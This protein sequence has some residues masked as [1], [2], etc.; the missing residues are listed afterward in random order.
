[1]IF[2]SNKNPIN[3][4]ILLSTFILLL[5]LYFLTLQFH[6]FISLRFRFFSKNEISFI[7][8]KLAFKYSN[9]SKIDIGDKSLT[10]EELISRCLIFLFVIKSD[11]SEIFV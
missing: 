11:I 7:F 6:I 9:L 3:H 8:V 1:M 4:N 10:K 2:I 5:N